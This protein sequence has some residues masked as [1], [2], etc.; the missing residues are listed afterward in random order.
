M[1]YKHY[2]EALKFIEDSKLSFTKNYLHSKSEKKGFNILKKAI[3]TA[4][5]VSI[6]EID[7]LIRHYQIRFIPDKLK[8][9][10]IPKPKPI[11]N[12]IQPYMFDSLNN[13]I[14]KTKNLLNFDSNEQES[15][16]QLAA[17]KAAATDGDSVFTEE[18]LDAKEKQ[19]ELAQE[20]ISRLKM[21]KEIKGP[22]SELAFIL[23]GEESTTGGNP[24]WTKPDNETLQEV[25]NMAHKLK[26]EDPETYKP[27]RGNPPL[28]DALKY[29]LS[30]KTR[31]PPSTLSGWFKKYIK[32][33]NGYYSLKTT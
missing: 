16:A 26:K 29:D 13:A 23:I 10:N 18:L 17:R 21:L 15:F 24:Y 5:V 2:P 11:Q 30:H 6:R 7:Q 19:K 28:P 14:S 31:I 8:E 1:K 32:K 9:H 20:L 33:E 27:K 22:Y 25:I 3:G 4:A 12:F